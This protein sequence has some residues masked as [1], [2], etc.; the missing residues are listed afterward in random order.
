M[1]KLSKKENV[2]K[3]EMMLPEEIATGEAVEI[4][5]L[6]SQVDGEEPMLENIE[7]IIWKNGESDQADRFQ[8]KN[9][10]NGLYTVNTIVKEEGLHFVKVEANTVD[11]KVMPTKQFVVGS[12]SEED[13]ESFPQQSEH[14]NREGHH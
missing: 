7:F 11:S 4:K 8:P 1:R 14:Q 3:I 2:L 6:M 9:Q 13:I 10:G 5:A 12:L